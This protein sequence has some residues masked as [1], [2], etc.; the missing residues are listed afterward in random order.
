MNLES[1]NDEI[2]SELLNLAG[3]TKQIQWHGFLEKMSQCIISKYKAGSKDEYRKSWRKAFKENSKRLGLKVVRDTSHSDIWAEKIAAELKPSIVDTASSSVGNSTSSLQYQRILTE[4][5][6]TLMKHMYDKI[7]EKWALKEGV[8][9]EDVIYNEA[10]DYYVEHPL[11]SYILHINDNKLVDMFK[12][13][14]IEE[15]EK[16]SGKA[17]LVK[18]LPEPL[19]T[20]LM[21]LDEKVNSDS[22]FYLYSG[23][24]LFV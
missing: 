4:K 20:M 5:D 15:I 12:P 6:K 9:V 10:K 13:E 18:A 19:A 16:E 2:A 7:S 17:D 3:D 11:H 24:L 1:L 14:E 22:L 21:N 23:I 8:I